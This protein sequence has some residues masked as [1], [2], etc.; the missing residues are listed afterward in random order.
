[1][2]QKI[3]FR[4]IPDAED[5]YE[6]LKTGQIHLAMNLDQ[7]KDRPEENPDFKWHKSINTLSVI[8]FLNG[9]EAPFNNPK[10]DWQSILQLM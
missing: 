10:P 4:I 6:M 7:L 5:R 9:F 2:Y 3:E 1:M 8:G